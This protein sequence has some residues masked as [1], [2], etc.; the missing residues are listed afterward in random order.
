MSQEKSI[1]SVTTAESPKN[2]PAALAMRAGSFYRSKQ[3]G[4]LVFCASGCGPGVIDLS[5]GWP[6]PETPVVAISGPDAGFSLRGLFGRVE[7]YELV[8]VE[9]TIKPRS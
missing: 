1:I 3:D 7:D 9:I 5:T 4:G 2:E 8:D 6:S